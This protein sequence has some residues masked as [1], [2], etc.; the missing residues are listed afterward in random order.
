MNNPKSSAIVVIMQ[1]LHE[2]DVSGVILERR[3]FAGVYDHIMLPME[4]DTRPGRQMLSKLGAEDPRTEEGEL[5]FEERF[6]QDVVDDLKHQLG[7][8]AAAGQLQ[9]EPAPRGGGIIQDKWWLL[10]EWDE[11]PPMDYVCMAVDTAY[12]E[13]EEADYTAI[14][15]WAAFQVDAGKAAVSASVTRYGERQPTERIYAEGH[16]HVL[17]KH[18]WRGKVGFPDLVK[19]VIKIATDHQVDRVLIEDKAAGVSLSQEL[20]RAFANEQ[21]GIQLVKPKGLDKVSRLYSVQH[22]FSEGLI[23]AP[24]KDWAEMVIRECA[25]FPKGKNDDLVD[26]VS[27]ALRHM[28]EAGILQRPVERLYELEE[29]KRWRGRAPAPLYPA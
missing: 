17:L 29:L 9:Q 22:L 16:P 11:E 27:Y 5:L 6:P 15:V 19:R 4:Y 7:P 13:K 23:W 20:R 21:F 8:Y 12:L 3:G 1:R 28:R 26:T 25:T 18:A 24:D 10:W 2:E 14:T